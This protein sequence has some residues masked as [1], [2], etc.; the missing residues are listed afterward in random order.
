M[1]PRMSQAVKHGNTVY[2]A[3]QVADDPTGDVAAQTAEVLAK[4]D[5]LLATAGSDKA[6]LLFATIWLADVSDYG[7]VNRVWDSWVAAGRPPARACVESTLAGPEYKLEIA[8]VAA[9]RSSVE[10]EG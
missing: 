4:V 3:G 9:S 2:I 7:E 5:L 1:G 8:A 6:H 10:D